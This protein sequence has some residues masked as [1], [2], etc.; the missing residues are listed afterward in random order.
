MSLFTLD[1]KDGVITNCAVTMFNHVKIMTQVAIWKQV[2]SSVSSSVPFY[3]KIRTS[4]FKQ[5]TKGDI[6]ADDRLAH[7][8]VNT[9]LFNKSNRTDPYWLFNISGMVIESIA[10]DHLLMTGMPDM[11]GNFDLD[12]GMPGRQQEHTSCYNAI[13]DYSENG[14]YYYN[15]EDDDPCQP[16]VDPRYNTVFD[17]PCEMGLGVTCCE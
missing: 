2:V 17:T 8:V 4:I 9:F 7:Q 5:I 10:P 13:T 12:G 3:T 11:N 15:F 6:D 16:P 1:N 14:G